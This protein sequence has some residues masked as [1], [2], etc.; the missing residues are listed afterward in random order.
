[1]KLFKGHAVMPRLGNGPVHVVRTYLAIADT[2]QDARASIANCEPAAEFVTVPAEM[3][4][5]LMVDVRS[6]TDGE[7]TDLRSACEW[8]EGRLR[9]GLR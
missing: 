7:C 5:P 4:E 8:N 6:L 9:N 3:S 2:W 1:M